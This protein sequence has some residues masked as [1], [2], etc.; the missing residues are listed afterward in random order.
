MSIS[1]SCPNCS[2]AFKAE[3]D[4]IGK[5][6]KCSSCGE[7]F[8][9]T[10]PETGDPPTEPKTSKTTAASNENSVSNPRRSV[11]LFIRQFFSRDLTM[12]YG[13]GVAVV[14]L[15]VGYFIGREHVKYE[16]RSVFA[17]AGE[18]LQEGMKEVF[19]ADPNGGAIEN[20]PIAAAN[21]PVLGFDEVFDG[22]SFLLTID[23]VRIDYVKLEPM[24]GDE[25]DRSAEKHLI[26][27]FRVQNSDDRKILHYKQPGLL[28]G[29]FFTI[30]DDVDNVIR[31]VSFGST[32]R[33]IGELAETEDILP[34][35]VSTHVAVFTIPPPK[36]RHLIAAVD[37]R[38]FHAQGVAKFRIKLADITGFTD[39]PCKFLGSKEEGPRH[40]DVM[41]LYA[42][43]GE[44]DTEDL[45]SFCRERKATMPAEEHY[46][47]VIFDGAKHAKFPTRPFMFLYD[48]DEHVQKHI[49]AIYKYT[50]WKEQGEL[51]YHEDNIYQHEANV[52]KI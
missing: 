38:A 20:D 3:V 17:D 4:H 34:G 31:G 1:L 7:T 47:V 19:P 27:S 39:W 14:A 45:R 32:N 46:F 13:I 24:F 6:A 10:A 35:D 37:L 12:P 50:R 33:I 48:G 15:V 18:A 25:Q 52:E 41:E 44:I 51:R 43:S 28:E 5:R 36:T 22:G 2:R 16:I 29:S 23:D 8:V 11:T 9:I 42:F 26:V 40:R 21:I 30:R 49:R